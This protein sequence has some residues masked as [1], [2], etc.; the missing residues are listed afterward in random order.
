M[1]TKKQKK[2][3]S[4]TSKEKDVN[5]DNAIE[6]KVVAEPAVDV[7]IAE[8]SDI[9]FE[10]LLSGLAPK[11]STKS[12]GKIGFELLLDLGNNSQYIRLISNDSGGLF[13]KKMVKL[14]DLYEVL[15]GM[16]EGISFKSSMFQHLITGSANNV[17]FLSAALRC[18]DLALI[19]Q[20]EK[21]QYLHI[22]NPLL[23]Q[24]K[25]LLTKLKPLAE[26]AKKI[27]VT[28]K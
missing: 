10:I 17:S 8:G 12:S 6:K 3:D 28:N 20:S 5:V 16:E 22:V 4:Q 1:N 24:R 25:S 19:L 9:Q 2:D 26:S 15:E 27:T 14:D 11:L 13:S 21:N 23:A 7:E 18:N